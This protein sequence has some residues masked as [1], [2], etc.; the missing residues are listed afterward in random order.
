M[1]M[2]KRK[3]RDRFGIKRALVGARGFPKGLEVRLGVA[4]L[5]P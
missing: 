2:M 5:N 1:N 4:G 3:S